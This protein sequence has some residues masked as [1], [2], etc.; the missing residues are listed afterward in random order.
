MFDDNNRLDYDNKNRSASENDALMNKLLMKL[1]RYTVEDLKF[2]V[3][4]AQVRE[5]KENDIK[6]K[7]GKEERERLEEIR[8]TRRRDQIMDKYL[9][10]ICPFCTKRLNSLSGLSIHLRI[11]HGYPA[12]KIRS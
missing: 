3:L 11:I 10:P 7:E 5:T 2:I 6:E 1:G 9:D 12:N 4:V 8:G